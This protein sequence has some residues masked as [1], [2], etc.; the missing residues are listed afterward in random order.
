MYV[1]IAKWGFCCFMSGSVQSIF[2]ETSQ[3]IQL[4]HDTKYNWIKFTNDLY[5]SGNYRDSGPCV[6]IEEC[7][8]SAIFAISG[9][10]KSWVLSLIR[11]GRQKSSLKGHKK[12]PQL[13]T[14]SF[15]VSFI[16]YGLQSSFGCT[17]V[18]GIDNNLPIIWFPVSLTFRVAASVIYR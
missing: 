9:C 8:S 14:F 6:A 4:L 18:Y 3:F 5:W 16:Q 15:S 10:W 1:Q 12:W 11:F 13:F 2:D 17:R 7:V